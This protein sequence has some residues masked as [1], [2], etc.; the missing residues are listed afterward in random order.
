M[1]THK[2]TKA[3][4]LAV[5]IEPL[6]DRVVVT[7]IEKETVTKSGIYIPDTASGDKPSEGIIVA[8]G[9]GGIRFEGKEL[10]NP[11]E[12]LK[13]GDHVLFGRYAGD[14]IKVKT[15]EGKEIEIKVLRLDSILGKVKHS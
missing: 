15:T 1:A 14:E 13:V 7:P 5:E 11:A 2:D 8:L 9:K 12:F 3:P 4:K 6:G 10:S